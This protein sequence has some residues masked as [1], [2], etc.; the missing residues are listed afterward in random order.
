[1][2]NVPFQIS[3]GE[4]PLTCTGSVSV[5]SNNAIL[6]PLGNYSISGRAP[7]C[8]LTVMPGTGQTGSGIFTVTVRDGMKYKSVS[9]PVSISLEA[10]P[11]VLD[12]MVSPDPQ[13]DTE[14]LITLNYTDANGDMATSCNILSIS[15]AS[16]S[17]PCS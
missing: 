15:N 13:E 16:V 10:P 7:N 5:S 6:F 8:V 12:F 11:S 4:N 1:A 17:T 2:F 3:G 9:F 14:S